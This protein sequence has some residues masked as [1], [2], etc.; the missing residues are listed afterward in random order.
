MKERKKERR[1]LRVSASSTCSL[2]LFGF[3]V[4]VSVC[5]ALMCAIRPILHLIEIVSLNNRCCSSFNE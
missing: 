1:S 4:A 3:V 2:D 5:A